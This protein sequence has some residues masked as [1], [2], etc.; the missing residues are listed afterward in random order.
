MSIAADGARQWRLNPALRRSRFD[1]AGPSQS[2]LLELDRIDGSTRR[3][4]ISDR[5]DALLDHIGAGQSPDDLLHSLRV[6]GAP[7]NALDLIKQSLETFIA[8]GVVI[9]PS[10][11]AASD[12]PSTRQK[13]SYVSAM[14][15][16]LGPAVIN[17]IAP[18]L[19]WLFTP[20]ALLVGGALG[21][22]GLVLLVQ[23]LRS[24][25]LTLGFDSA[26]VLAIG[27]L[28]GIGVVLHELG[29]AIAAF[30]Y[31]ARRVDIGIGWYFVLPVAYAN[32][33]EAWR[34]T[35]L[36]RA[37]I[38]LAG[39]HMQLLWTFV[40]MLT[41]R[42]D[43]GALYLAAA[44]AVAVMTL[45]NLNPLIRMDGYWLAT[46]LLGSTQLREEVLAALRSL[47]RRQRLEP[48]ACAAAGWRIYA[49]TAYAVFSSLFFV[50]LI[51]WAFGKFARAV[52]YT[53]PG[54][55]AQ[56][57]GSWDALSASDLTLMLITA[58]WNCLV[59]LMLSRF[60]LRTLRSAA[61]FIRNTALK[62]AA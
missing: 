47:T 24:P 13:P 45:W 32:L 51:F 3:F 35:R 49:L 48:Q 50:F 2:R 11:A 37:V 57:R 18:G 34:F 33:S 5:M 58:L 9:A 29:H 31:G 8:S 55:W 17:R 4:V 27:V 6:D 54:I 22:V 14:L 25:P 12:Q 30:R 60:F 46:D 39:V 53:F 1:G 56:L 43:G 52:G 10:G 44:T 36:Q 21:I 59:L 62:R 20:L 40:L 16:L 28:C 23:G 7:G 61:Q 38:D 15:P 41:Y 19:Q 26:D 42:F